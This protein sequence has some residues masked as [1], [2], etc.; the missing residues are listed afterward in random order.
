ML[1]NIAKTHN[2]YARKF[3]FIKLITALDK[4]SNPRAPKL[5]EF[6]LYKDE[7]DNRYI[8]TGGAIILSDKEAVEA[9]EAYAT[10]STEPVPAEHNNEV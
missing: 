8:E 4:E 3:E 10:A 7:H 9:L 2:I 1:E 5:V 6:N